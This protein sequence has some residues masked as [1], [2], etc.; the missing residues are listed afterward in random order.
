MPDIGHLFVGGSYVSMIEVQR[1]LWKEASHYRLR[2]L[3]NLSYTTRRGGGKITLPERTVIV[4]LVFIS[5]LPSVA[6]YLLQ[7]P[8]LHFTGAATY[9]EDKAQHEAWATEMAAHLWYQN[10]LTPEQ[11]PR[12]WFLTPLELFLGLIQRVTGI[13]YD[14]AGDALWLGCAPLLAF[15][16]L[17]LPRQSVLAGLELR[18]PPHC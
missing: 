13:P 18:P 16:L 7:P 8:G 9:A 14:L 1:R 3:L 6:G 17:T 2:P 15:A 12:G 11:T 10:L 4:L 5:M